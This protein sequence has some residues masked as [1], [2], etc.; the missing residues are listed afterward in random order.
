MCTSKTPVV[1][2]V[3][4]EIDYTILDF[5]A[6][7]RAPTPSAAAELLCPDQKEEQNKI[8][9]I[10]ENIHKNM[11]ER[12]VLWYNETERV[13]ELVEQSGRQLLP[14]KERALSAQ[15]EALRAAAEETLEKKQTL[16]QGRAALAHALDPMGV[17]ARGYLMARDQKGRPLGLETVSPG[18]EIFLESTCHLAGCTVNE[19]QAKESL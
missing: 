7:L 2:A 1:S 13:R 19:I 17:L 3:G 14:L 11:Q 16:L 12:L 4:H 6:D 8:C 9:R 15:K 18:Q 5:A 10:Y